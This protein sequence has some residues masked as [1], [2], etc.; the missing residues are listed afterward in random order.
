[1][2]HL[3]TAIQLLGT[4]IYKTYKTKE[5]LLKDLAILEKEVALAEKSYEEKLKTSGRWG[6]PALDYARKALYR[7]QGELQDL[8]NA[9]EYWKDPVPPHADRLS[10]LLFRACPQRCRAT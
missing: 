5:E 4:G 10:N 8:Q 7:L 9:A 3:K 6:S 1:M 2:K